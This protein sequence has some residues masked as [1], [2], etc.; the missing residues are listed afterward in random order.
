MSDLSE[1]VGSDVNLQAEMPESAE[2]VETVEAQQPTQEP[3]QEAAEPAEQA[4]PQQQRTVPLAAL[5]EERARRRELAQQMEQLRAQQAERDR[6]IEERLQALIQSQ[7]PKPPA[8]DENPAEHLRQQ[9][10]NLQQTQ[11]ASAEQIERMNQAYAAEQARAALSQRVL[12][13]EEA[14]KAAKPDYY[15]ALKHFGGTRVRELMAFGVEQEAARQQVAQEMQQHAFWCAQN[16]KDPAEIAYNLA[17]ARGYSA[18]P[19]G[20]PA[21]DK[22][23]MQQR[24]MAASKSLG[25]GGAAAPKTTVEALLAMSD[26]DFAEATKGNKWA[27]LFG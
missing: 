4:E 2:P 21:A 8:F 7:Q 16:G 18:K 25:S 20:V 10:E 17:V 15:D 9:L 1:I 14:F 22:M 3:A 12:A 23:Q 11:K 13:A 26:E 5:H 24:G 19:A 6:V 27:K